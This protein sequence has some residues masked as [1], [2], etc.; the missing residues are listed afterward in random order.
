ML[1]VLVDMT[2]LNTPSRERGI[3]RYV[4]N[5]C[6]ALAVRDGWLSEADAGRQLSLAGLVRHRGRVLG[7]VDPSLQFAGDPRIKISSGQYQRHKMERRFF[8]GGLARRT[9]ARLLHL[10]DPFG[11]PIDTRL[12]RIVT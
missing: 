10:G 12:P 1:D 2:A 11:T 9:G 6:H 7:A 5:L 4:K 8:L 3:G